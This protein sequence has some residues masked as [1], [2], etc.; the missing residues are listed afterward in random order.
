[1][2]S[3]EM[4]YQISLRFSVKEVINNNNAVVFGHYVNDPERYGVVF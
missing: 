4:D 2:F 1:M 3:T